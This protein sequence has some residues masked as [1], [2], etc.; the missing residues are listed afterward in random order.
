MELIQVRAINND[1]WFIESEPFRHPVTEKLETLGCELHVKFD[2][3]FRF[4]TAVFFLQRYR[5]I[6]MEKIDDRT[7]PLEQTFIN[8]RIVEPD[9]I[10]IH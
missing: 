9:S 4:P 2:N 10:F 1:K 3:V 7:Y 5:H 8:D 6:E